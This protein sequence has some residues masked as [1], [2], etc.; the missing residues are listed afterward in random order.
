VAYC[1][2]RGIDKSVATGLEYLET[3]AKGGYRMALTFLGNMYHKGEGVEQSY[4]RAKTYFETAATQGDD[5]AQLALARMYINGWGVEKNSEEANRYLHLSAEQGHPIAC[6]TLGMKYLNGQD[7]RTSTFRALH[8]MSQAKSSSSPPQLNEEVEKRLNELTKLMVTQR[9]AAL[10]SAQHQF[11]LASGHA[12]GQAGVGKSLPA[13]NFWYT[14]AVAQGF[15][16]AIPMLA[17]LT[18]MMEKSGEKT[19][20][21]DSV[22]CSTCASLVPRR[23]AP[24]NS[25]GDFLTCTCKMA[26]YCSKECQKEG[27]KGHAKVHKV[28]LAERDGAERK[29]EEGVAAGESK[30]GAEK[31]AGSGGKCA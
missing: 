31:V 15:G 29:V 10:G 25:P 2:G 28:G 5:M 8:Y 27:W 12:N 23:V 20:E 21:E 9:G 24:M 17:L 7:V 18:T 3:A 4:T 19:I 1:T 14:K 30:A 11:H 6:F 13:A 22:F 16:Q 26:S